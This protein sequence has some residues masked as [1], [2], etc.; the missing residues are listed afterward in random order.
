VTEPRE[1]VDVHL[2]DALVAL[3]LEA[4]RSARAV[5]DLGAGAGV[6]GLPLAVGLPEARVQLVESAGRKATFLRRA[7][8]A[9][10]LANAEVVA[11]RAEAWPEGLGSSDLVTARALAPL[12]VLVEYAAPLLVE[13]GSLVAWKGRRDPAE[14]AAGARA[15]RLLGLE[16]AEVRRVEPW[17]RAHDHHV[18]VYAKV[19]P[20]PAGFPRRP[21]VARKRPLGGER[22]RPT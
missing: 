3:D 6:P 10:R 11:A 19:R 21:G 13:G 4:V 8:Q 22:S 14:E 2:A 5:A 16:P 17:P 7:V 9:M 1:A 18:H 15:A 12:D 20:T